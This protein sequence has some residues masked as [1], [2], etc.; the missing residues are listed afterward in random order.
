[1]V[2]K[3]TMCL[4]KPRYFLKRL[5]GAALTLSSP[6]CQDTQWDVVCR[7][8]GRW[9]N[10]Y[11]VW[12]NKH[13]QFLLQG[14]SARSAPPPPPPETPPNGTLFAVFGEAQVMV[15]IL[16]SLWKEALTISS[17]GWHSSFYNSSTTTTATRFSSKVDYK[18][19][20]HSMIAISILRRGVLT[21]SMRQ[22]TRTDSEQS[23]PSPGYVA[24]GGLPGHQMETCPHCYRQILAICLAAHLANHHNK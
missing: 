16:I 1:M 21:R 20:H 2:V 24:R 8:W 17:P 14:D 11:Y 3:T 4:R 12:K 19:C 10:D 6:E 18:F 15:V 9:G 23:L 7:V 13:W 5:W 22:R